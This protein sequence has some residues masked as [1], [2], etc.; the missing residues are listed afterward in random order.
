MALLWM[1]MNA[2]NILLDVNYTSAFSPLDDDGRGFRHYHISARL[3]NL[4]RRTPCL[5]TNFWRY[6]VAF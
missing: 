2:A 4:L 3:L 5:A 1:A 6:G